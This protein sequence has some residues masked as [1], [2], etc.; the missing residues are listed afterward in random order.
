MYQ[1]TENSSDIFLKTKTERKEE[2]ERKEEVIFQNQCLLFL[3]YLFLLK[4]NLNHLC[5]I[6]FFM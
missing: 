5:K 2:R 1:L 4:W 3:I 6:F